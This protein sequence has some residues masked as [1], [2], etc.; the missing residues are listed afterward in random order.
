MIRNLLLNDK[1][2]VLNQLPI[3][4]FSTN[5][6]GEILHANSEAESFFERQLGN[7]PKSCL[8]IDQQEST[9][10]L[11]T[12]FI[13]YFNDKKDIQDFPIL[14]NGHTFLISS[15]DVEDQEDNMH[16]FLLKEVPQNLLVTPKQ[17]IYADII[18]LSEDAIIT[19]D[20][21]GDIITW[22]FGAE[23]IFGFNA[24]EAIGQQINKLIGTNK[25]SET[26]ELFNTISRG[27][28]YRIDQTMR[29]N[30]A[31][32]LVD[33]S[34]TASPII[35]INHQVVG[36]SKIIRDISTD[37][38]NRRQLKKHNENLLHLNAVG[39]MISEKLDVQNI[40]QMVTDVTT[41]ITGAAYGAFFYNTLNSNGDAMKLYTL[42]GASRA[43][44][45]KLGMPRNTDLFKHTFTDK[46]ILRSGDVKAH[47]KFGNNAP[48]NGMPHG[49]LGVKSYLSVPVISGSGENMGTLLF[50]H[51]EP[52]VFKEEHEDMVLSVASQATVALEN[53]RL[54]ES[55]N[56][57]NSKKDEF[58]ALASHE[59]KTP[60]TTIK[61]YL[62][63]INEF[64][65]SDML[66]NFLDKVLEQV[67][68]LNGLISEMLD[69][70]KIEAGKIMLNKE[71]FL[72]ND[73]IEHTIQ[74]ISYSQST[75]NI[76]FH[77]TTQV[78][79]CADR[80]R[81]EQ[82]LLNLLMNAI[83]YSPSSNLVE[84]Y[85]TCEKNQ[86]IVKVKDF[87]IGI[88]KS[89]IIN[90]FSRFYR[91]ESD[92]NISGLGLGLYLSKEIVNRHDGSI[93]VESELGEGSE[94][95]FKIP[96]KSLDSQ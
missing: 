19:C 68:K 52:D 83:K 13:H 46:K 65:E 33:I 85:I 56:Q 32:D 95:I 27:L 57:M 49:H 54:F 93:I 76:I 60:L 91:V 78:S 92:T 25:F 87:G 86:A 18:D 41:K 74:T 15:F 4:V 31:G 3:V 58:I 10:L 20:L 29:I 1:F 79:V 37:T 11:Q 73:L 28:T 59:L 26:D 40:L 17:K 72:L 64:N 88:D 53:S 84:I 77:N 42:S 63:V 5:E 70:S 7:I 66:Q 43:D 62:Q 22:N 24:V 36:V 34:I 51:P 9:D 39:K 50:G 89:Q 81:M 80:F 6:L 38:D 94:F 48:L 47:Y 75:H 14:L 45:E 23:K 71:E 30:R 12:K 69:I 35:D 96:I 67:E 90:I 61:G 44:F 55:I 2:E 8:D 16:Y 82:V 21:K